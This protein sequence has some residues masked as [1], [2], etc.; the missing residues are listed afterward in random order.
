MKKERDLASVLAELAGHHA[1]A[2]ELAREAYDLVAAREK[3][4][5]QSSV[6]ENEQVKGNCNLVVSIAMCSVNWRGRCCILGPSL[7][8]RLMHRLAQHPDRFFTYDMLMD[9]VWERRCSDAALRALISRLRHALKDAGMPKL[10][11]AIRV[12]GR[13]V[14]L[15]LNGGAP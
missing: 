9:E 3:S 11:A 10:A 5:Q 1:V 2:A 7:P 15:F 8:L 4:S 12:Q 6:V 14:G 13:C